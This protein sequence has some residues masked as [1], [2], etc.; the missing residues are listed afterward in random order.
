MPT[1]TPDE[2]LQL[3]FNR[4][5]EEGR[6]EEMERHHLPITEP[7]V[8][9][10]A[11]KPGDRVLDLGCGAGWATRLLARMVAAE[12]SNAHNDGLVLGVDISDEM[13]RRATENSRD[14]SNVR[15]LVGSAEQIPSEA[16][17]FH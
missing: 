16:N 15:Y 12:K 8:R 10:M 9:M 11:L 5:A 13:I 2:K 1:I 6:G 14:L 17:F 7:V 3:E 4:W